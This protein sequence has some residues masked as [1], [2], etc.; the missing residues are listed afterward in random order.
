VTTCTISG[1]KPV[2]LKGLKPP[3]SVELQ[4]GIKKVWHTVLVA[5]A[6]GSN[7][8]FTIALGSIG[9]FEVRA[10]MPKSKYFALSVS[11]TFQIVVAKT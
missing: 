10:L 2:L 7:L 6:G 8:T 1:I 5:S 11:K 9:N 3:V 4:L